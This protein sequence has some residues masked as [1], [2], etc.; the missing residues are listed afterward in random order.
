MLACTAARTVQAILP[1]AV[2]MKARA[3]TT[4]AATK[5]AL[6]QDLEVC[7]PGPGILSPNQ[8]SQ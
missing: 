7:T 3:E 4:A 2:L 8:L 1:A 5:A 6:M